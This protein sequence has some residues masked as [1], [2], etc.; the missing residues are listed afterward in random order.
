MHDGFRVELDELLIWKLV[1]EHWSNCIFIHEVWTEGNR[2]CILKQRAEVS[3]S[4][5]I[6]L[7]CQITKSLWFE[8][9]CGIANGLSQIHFHSVFHGDLKWFVNHQIY[10]DKSSTSQRCRRWKYFK[11]PSF[12]FQSRHSEMVAEK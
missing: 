10:T 6:N 5:W 1:G 8:I 4:D 7:K 11:R 3:L 12:Y 9:M 2:F